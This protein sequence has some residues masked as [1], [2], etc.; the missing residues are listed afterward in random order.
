MRYRKRSRYNTEPDD[1]DIIEVHRRDHLPSSDPDQ[2]EYEFRESEGDLA[3]ARSVTMRRARSMIATKQRVPFTLEAL[4]H[5]SAENRTANIV[6]NPEDSLTAYDAAMDVILHYGRLVGNGNKEPDRKEECDIEHICSICTASFW[7]GFVGLN[8]G[9]PFRVGSYARVPNN[10][11][12]RWQ[13]C[14]N[15][16]S[17]LDR[18]PLYTPF[19]IVTHMSGPPRAANY[20]TAKGR[21]LQ[22]TVEAAVRVVHRKQFQRRV[23]EDRAYYRRRAR[24]LH[25]RGLPF[26]AQPYWR[27]RIL[28]A[29][30]IDDPM[31][32]S[33]SFANGNMQT[34]PYLEGIP[35]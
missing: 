16:A 6:F 7:C 11:W 10:H 19:D 29:P 34:W 21:A 17:W 26:P 20:Y 5:R 32:H 22:D 1:R 33:A 4:R 12:R 28:R 13:S 18:L 14:N 25:Q 24:S 8:L 2:D 9:C 27:M 15:C 3:H 23:E 30:Y 35:Q 31:W